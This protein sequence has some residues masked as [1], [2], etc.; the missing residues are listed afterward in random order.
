MINLDIEPPIFFYLWMNMKDSGFTHVHF[1]WLEK[2]WYLMEFVE[3]WLVSGLL[4]SECSLFK[5]P[6]VWFSL[7]DSTGFTG[8]RERGLVGK[9]SLKGKDKQADERGKS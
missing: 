9:G 3:L 8:R 6:T 7:F 5:S 2:T 1:L 4:F